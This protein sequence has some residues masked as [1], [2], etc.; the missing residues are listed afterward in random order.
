MFWGL[1][2]PV[3]HVG[4]G[5]Q[6]WAQTPQSLGTTSATV[7]ILLWVGHPP[8]GIGLNYTMTPSLLPILSWVL[9]YIFS[10]RRSFSFVLSLFSLIVALS[11]AV[12]LFYPWEEVWAQGLPI[13]SS[14]PLPH[15]HLNVLKGYPFICFRSFS[16]LSPLRRKFVNASLLLIRS[17]VQGI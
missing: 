15:K 9:L 4:W 13:L 6:D 1:L 11:K 2:L 3:P 5:A 7:I 16:M 10:C 17:P 12:V 14:W 8:G